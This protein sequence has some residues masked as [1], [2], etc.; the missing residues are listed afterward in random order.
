MNIAKLRTAIFVS[1]NSTSTFA[2]HRCFL[3][4]RQTTDHEVFNPGIVVETKNWE[5]SLPTPTVGYELLGNERYTLLPKRLIAENREYV[6]ISQL[7]KNSCLLEYVLNK[8]NIQSIWGFGMNQKPIHV[9]D[10]EIKNDLQ[11]DPG[12]SIQFYELT[13]PDG[14][15][16]TNFKLISEYEAA[17]HIGEIKQI[18]SYELSEFNE[19]TGAKLHSR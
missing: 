11:V 1:H 15:T 4:P 13:E 10:I 16:A 3:D 7:K 18:R 12:F 9:F 6:F 14:D 5:C 19:M 8:E 17:I 2:E